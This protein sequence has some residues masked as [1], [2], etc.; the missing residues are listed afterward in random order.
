MSGNWY[1][2]GMKSRHTKEHTGIVG[3]RHE[4]AVDK[5]KDGRFYVTVVWWTDTG[6]LGLREGPWIAEAFLSVQPSGPVI[7]ELIITPG[8]EVPPGGLTKTFLNSIPIGEIQSQLRMIKEV[9][10]HNLERQPG[11]DKW[12]R[13]FKLDEKDIEKAK[14]KRG[15]PGRPL[16]FYAQVARDY[17]AAF[18]AGY[19]NPT[20]EVKRARRNMTREQA[21]DAVSRARRE[22]LLTKPPRPGIPGGWLTPKAKAVLKNRK[23]TSKG[24]P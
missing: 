6:M 14:R 5:N 1:I 9:Y 12:R 21:R 24:K 3:H 22:G 19:P 8:G 2:P 20:A 16:L 13:L 10:A 7:G 11:D 15:R 4:I 17:D 18:R 23:K